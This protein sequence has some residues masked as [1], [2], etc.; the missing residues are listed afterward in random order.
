MNRRLDPEQIEVVDDD[1][2]T[3]L[4]QKTPA[5]R[6]GMAA[7]CN[8][9]VRFLIATDIVRSHPQLTE[10]QVQAEVARRMLRAAMRQNEFFPICG[11][12]PPRH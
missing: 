11:W 6:I 1:M 10:E 9:A 8:R 2:V 4:R 5:E 12:H 3:I 7:D